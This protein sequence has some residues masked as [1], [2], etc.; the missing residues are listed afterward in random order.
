MLFYYI[1]NLF[2]GKFTIFFAHWLKNTHKNFALSHIY[3]NFAAATLQIQSKVT[4]FFVLRAASIITFAMNRILSI[5]L[6]SCLTAMPAAAQTTVTPYTPGITPAGITYFLPKTSVRFIV[7]ATRTTH[8]PG[9]YAAYAERYLGITDAT[10]SE[11]DVWTLDDVSLVAFGTP[12]ASQAYTIDLNPK[13]TAPLVTMTPDGRLLAIN[14]ETP[15]P[16]P[17]EGPKVEKVAAERIAAGDFF[18]P[19]MLRATSVAKKAELAAQEIYDI[20]ENRGLIAKGQADFNPTDGTQLQ[21][22]LQELDRSERALTSLF[23]GHSQSEHHTFVIDYT[24][25]KA[26][27]GEQLFRFSRHLGMVDADDLAGEP[28]LISVA[29]ETTLPAPVVDPKAKTKEVNDVRYRIPGRAHITLTTGQRTICEAAVPVAQFGRVEHLGGEL[30]V[31][32]KVTTHVRLND[33]TGNIEHID[34]VPQTK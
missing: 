12:D 24:P 14:A 17:L 18:T 7:K 21:L 11:F 28:Y 29:D 13:S 10:L 30:F 8:F 32:K 5:A 1:S 20:R 16:A 34:V 23:T 6:F 22:M 4:A 19:E 33:V 9:E 2:A 15:L 25:E 31:A 27:D 26:V 3:Y